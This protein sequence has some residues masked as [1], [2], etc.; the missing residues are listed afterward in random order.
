MLLIV[1]MEIA[2]HKGCRVRDIRRTPERDQLHF[3]SGKIEDVDCL[4]IAV[5]V[6]L[7]ILRDDGLWY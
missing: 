5:P 1:L 2:E 4:K 7:S 6:P 3:F